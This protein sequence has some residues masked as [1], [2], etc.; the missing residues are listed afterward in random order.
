MWFHKRTE[1]S[2]QDPWKT[3]LLGYPKVSEAVHEEMYD[4]IKDLPIIPSADFKRAYN[5]LQFP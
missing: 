3:K 4:K 2:N 5:Y 1:N